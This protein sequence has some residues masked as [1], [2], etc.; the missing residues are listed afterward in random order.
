MSSF[1]V[2]AVQA[3][4]TMLYIGPMRARK[5]YE[6]LVDASKYTSTD[7]HAFRHAFD[8]RW[9][10]GVI[11]SRDTSVEPTVCQHVPKL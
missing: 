6:L 2:D 4:R 9:T 1:L 11:Q 3:K 10:S 8:T 7:Y 5:S